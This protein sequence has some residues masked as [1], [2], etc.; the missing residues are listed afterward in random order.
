MGILIVWFYST[1]GR[2][3]ELMGLSR[4]APAE[5]HVIVGGDRV[6]SLTTTR[7]NKRENQASR[8][9]GWRQGSVPDDDKGKQ[10]GELTEKATRQVGPIGHGTQKERVWHPMMSGSTYQESLLL[11]SC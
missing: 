2:A 8:D 4:L 7:V 3:G 9:R 10:V 5:H 1:W 6:A 11:V